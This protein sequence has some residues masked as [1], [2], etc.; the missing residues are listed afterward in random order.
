MAVA[1]RVNEI[2]DQ[3]M[4]YREEGIDAKIQVVAAAPLVVLWL[5]PTETTVL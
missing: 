2:E 4:D 5:L 1:K 3:F